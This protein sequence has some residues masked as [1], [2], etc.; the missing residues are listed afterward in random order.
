MNLG[1]WGGGEDLGRVGEGKTVHRIYCI[2]KS[3]FNFLK[4]GKDG[5][6]LSKKQEP[7]S[8]LKEMVWQINSWWCTAV[9]SLLW[10]HTG[11]N[12]IFWSDRHVSSVALLGCQRTPQRQTHPKQGQCSAC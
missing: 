4:K 9:E 6:R 12:A 11:E 3:I 8:Q 2:K 10:P 7:F 5:S 1:V